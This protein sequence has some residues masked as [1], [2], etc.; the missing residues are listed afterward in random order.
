MVGTRRIGLVLSCYPSLPIKECRIA[1]K[2]SKYRRSHEIP[3]ETTA[4]DKNPS[5][6]AESR[7]FP[8]S[9]DT[10]NGR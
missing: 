10:E 3:E 5:Y 1:S 2:I 8:I 9:Q 4:T 7:R 6:N